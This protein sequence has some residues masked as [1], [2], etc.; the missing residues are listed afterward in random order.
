MQADRLRTS[1][2]ALSGLQIDVND[3]G[4]AEIRG[5]APTQ[6]TRMLIENLVRLEP[7]IR[8][9]TNLVEVVPTPPAATNP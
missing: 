7:G 6:D 8:E 4:T 5:K 2:P 1:N 9:V 3:E